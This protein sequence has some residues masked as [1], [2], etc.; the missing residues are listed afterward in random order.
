MRTDGQTVRVLVT[1]TGGLKHD[2]ITSWIKAV[3]AAMDFDGIEVDAIAWEGTPTD[4][5]DAVCACVTDVRIVPSRRDDVFGYLRTL[6]RLARGRRYDVFHVCGSS[7]LV[8]LEL[9]VAARCG[10]PV[11]VTHS[12]NTACQHA[13]LDKALRPF[14]SRLSTN[15]LACGEDAGRWLFG[16]DDFLVL[17]NGKDVG[18]Y[19]YDPELRS[20]VRRELMIGDGVVAIGHVGRFNEQKNHDFLIRVFAELSVRPGEHVLCLIGDGEGMVRAKELA[21]SLGVGASVLF[22]GHRRDVARL[23]N[24][25]DCMVLPSRYEGFPNVVLEWQLNGLPCVLSDAITREA[26]LTPLVR[27]ACLSDAPALWADTVESA[28]REAP[29]RKK[30]SVESTE[31]LV[32]AGYDIRES[33]RTLK[34]LY[35]EEVCR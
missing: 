6:R 13:L 23:L 30:A 1:S 4:V 7:G 19:R 35:M 29:N 18:A 17:P 10:V 32:R 31:A 9:G 20:K 14:M 28:V 22:L 16:E 21:E 26:S 5:L 3:Y 11:R 25:M 33:A 15:R 8:A 24:A 27:Y 34:A 12:H 2:G